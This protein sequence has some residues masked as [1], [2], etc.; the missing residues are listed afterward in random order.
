MGSQ[1]RNTELRQILYGRFDTLWGNSNGMKSM[2]TRM[3]PAIIAV[4]LLAGCA[5]VDPIRT[6]QYVNLNRFMGDWYVIAAIPTAIEAKAYNAVESYELDD[7]GRVATTFTFRKGGFGGKLKEYHPTGFVLDDSNAIWDMQ[8][9]WP[10]KADYRI[11]YVDAAYQQT[12]IGRNQRDYAW[13]MARSPQIPES[14]YRRLV[15]ML[16]VEGYDIGEIRKVPQ[17]WTEEI[18]ASAP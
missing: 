2:P 13:I 6:E 8:F 4:A 11:V 3:F 5:N 16:A 1:L 7:K 14:D 17:N 18:D 10:F 15:D 12:I 9:L